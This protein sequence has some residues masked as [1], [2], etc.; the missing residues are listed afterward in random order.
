MAE[1]VQLKMLVN[2]KYTG[3]NNKARY[4]YTSADI[5]FDNKSIVFMKPTPVMV[6]TTS[7]LQ[8][9]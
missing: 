5:L 9:C 7:S 4:M 1:Q 3:L 2:H 6:G 8:T